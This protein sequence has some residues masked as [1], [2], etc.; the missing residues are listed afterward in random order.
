MCVYI[1]VCVYILY[2]YIYIHTH[3]IFFIHSFV[4]KYLGCFH[5]LAT[6]NNVSMN[7]GVRCIFLNSVCVSFRYMLRV[8]L[9]DHMVVLFFNFLRNLQTSSTVDAS[10][11]IPTNSVLELPFLHILAD[12]CWYLMTAILTG[13]TWY[14]TV[15]LTCLSWWLAML[16]IFSRVCWP[17]VPL[18]R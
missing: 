17:S 13:M 4:D 3:H 9:L 11:Y 14:L 2:T 12:I 16:S 5:I 18:F 7:T 10:R 1:Y 15:V 6:V 8:E